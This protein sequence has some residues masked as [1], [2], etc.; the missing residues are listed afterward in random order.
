M[1]HHI[2]Y[3]QAG[4]GDPVESQYL[5]GLDRTMLS[6]PK[7]YNCPLFLLAFLLSIAVIYNW[8]VNENFGIVTIDVQEK[9]ETRAQLAIAEYVH[10]T[11]NETQGGFLGGKHPQLLTRMLAMPNLVRHTLRRIWRDTFLSGDVQRAL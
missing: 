8:R 2:E 1:V 3:L 5:S 9:S 4:V 7:G 10:L 6:H 11:N